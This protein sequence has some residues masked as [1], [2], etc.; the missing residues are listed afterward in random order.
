LTP[1][2]PQIGQCKQRDQLRRI[3]LQATVTNLDMTKLAL[4]DPKWVLFALSNLWMVR[5]QLLGVQA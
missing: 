5:G 3:L 4:N 1:N 2:H